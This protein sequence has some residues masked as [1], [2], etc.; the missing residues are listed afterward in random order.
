M[1]VMDD[2]NSQTDV[3]GTPCLNTS[4]ADLTKRLDSH[5]RGGEGVLSVDFTNVHIVTM[6]RTDPEFAR[7]TGNVDWF[8]PDSQVLKWAV[9]LCGGHMEE[10][11]YG[12]TFLDFAVRH[13]AAETRH[14][15]LGAS[16]DCLALLLA[17]LKEARP[18]LNVVGSHNGY[19]GDAENDAVMA[20]ILA[21]RPDIIWVGL[22]TPKQQKWI[23]ANKERF[24]RGAILAVGFAFD[25]NAGTKKDAPPWMGK[26]GLTWLYRLISEP[27]RLFTRY[28]Y[29][30][31]LFL[32]YLIQQKCGRKFR[33][34]A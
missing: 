8:V 31:T 28:A 20:D 27:R 16:Q 15:F 22:G 29:Y 21:A 1:T 12:P 9:N 14:Y 32:W 11:V 24:R 7:T 34:P 5:T 6:R 2:G 25:V 33:T 13:G 10:R 19:F 18:D 26:C 3:I 30:N 23:H 4:Y 17:K